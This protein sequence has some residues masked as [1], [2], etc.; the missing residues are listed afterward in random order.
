MT[1]KPPVGYLLDRGIGV[2]ALVLAMRTVLARR[3][4]RTPRPDPQ[5]KLPLAPK[6]GA[7]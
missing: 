7:A 2:H 1:P 6:R 5:L 3:P 4:K